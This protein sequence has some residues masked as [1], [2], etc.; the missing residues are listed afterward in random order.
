VEVES[1]K[2]KEATSLGAAGT[3]TGAE[4]RAC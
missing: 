3:L 4:D 1:V 2:D